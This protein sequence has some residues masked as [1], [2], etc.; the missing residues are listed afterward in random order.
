MEKLRRWV[1]CSQFDTKPRWHSEF[2]RRIHGTV[3][4]P[5]SPIQS[6]RNL[7]NSI[8]YPHLWKR[9]VP[10]VNVTVNYHCN[11]LKILFFFLHSLLQHAIIVFCSS[12]AMES[13]G[14]GWQSEGDYRGG[15]FTANHSK[16]KDILVEITKIALH[17]MRD[18]MM[19]PHLNISPFCVKLFE[20]PITDVLTVL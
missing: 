7:A 20:V 16:E 8:F 2:I 10:D 17:H 14:H 1:T 4:N 9:G 13:R 18:I 19:W 11:K 6:A 15:Y 3:K 12:L 5:V